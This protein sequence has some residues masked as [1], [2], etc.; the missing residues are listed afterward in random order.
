MDVDRHRR[1]SYSRPTAFLDPLEPVVSLASCD[2]ATV[3]VKT[4]DIPD[5]PFVQI[6][7]NALRAVPTTVTF[8]RHPRVADRATT[9][10]RIPA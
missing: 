10:I 9:T 3:T 2:R 1:R 5:Y 7:P 4:N 6:T 8:P